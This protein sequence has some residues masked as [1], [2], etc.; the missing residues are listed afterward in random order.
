MLHEWQSNFAGRLRAAPAAEMAG[1]ADFLGMQ[2]HRF[3]VYRDNMLGSLVEALGETFPVARQLVGD[4]FFDIVAA[5]FVRQEPPRTPRLSRYGS[6]LPVYLQTVPQLA[7]L[8]YVADVAMLEWARV[9]AYFAGVTEDVL[10]AETLLDRPVSILPHL[11]FKT[12]PSLRVVSAPTAIHRIWL[13][14][15]SETPDLS[16]LDPWQGEA[17]RLL[18]TS[19][20]IVA[21]LVTPAQATFLRDLQSGKALVMATDMAV[22]LDAAFDLQAMLAAELGAGSFSGIFLPATTDPAP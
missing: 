16:D 9:E 14:H 11:T 17:V 18:C 22:A 5:D 21:D 19:R 20:G 12:V 13:A 6:T 2:P 15:Q 7:D 1:D 8:S 4:R 3:S 10:T